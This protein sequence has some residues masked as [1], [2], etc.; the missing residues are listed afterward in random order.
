MHLGRKRGLSTEVKNIWRK[1]IKEENRDAWGRQASRFLVYW[2]KMLEVWHSWESILVGNCR[3]D[4]FEIIKKYIDKYT[5]TSACQAQ[6]FHKGRISPTHH[7][8]P[9]KYVLQLQ[10]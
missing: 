1:L 2:V 7:G 4:W 10:F 9:S 6:I 5:F 3:C 8:P